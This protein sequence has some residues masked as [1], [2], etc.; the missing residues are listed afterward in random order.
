MRNVEKLKREE[1]TCL[2]G[3]KHIIICVICM[4]PCG[5]VC[6]LDGV[7]HVYISEED[8]MHIVE[9]LCR[10][11]GVCGRVCNCVYTDTGCRDMRKV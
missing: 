9:R 2:W 8:R 5:G 7:S 10:E 4:H 3:C 11:E 6:I 1:G